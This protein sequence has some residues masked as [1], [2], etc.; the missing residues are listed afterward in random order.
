MTATSATSHRFVLRDLTFPARL[1]V[2]AFMLS[3]GIGYVSAIVNLHMQEASP[4]N[5]LPD[6]DDVV[7]VY[8]GNANASQ[9]ERVLTAHESL[10]F[11]GQGSMRA[12]FTRTRAGNIEPAV[13]AMAKRENCNLDDPAVRAH[14]EGAVLAE[15]DGERQALLAWVRA[16]YP[17]SAYDGDHG[18]ILPDS[19]K[20]LP[21]T[22]SCV[23][24]IDQD[25][26]PERCIKIQ[27]ILR[28]RCV[29]CH[30][31]DVG[32]SAAEYPLQTYEQVAVYCQQPGPGPSGKSLTKLA[33]TT[34][35]HLLGFSMLYGLTGL[36]LAF[37]RL[38]AI[39]RLIL[40]PLPLIAQ[41]LDISCWW[42]AR[43]EGHLGETFA[44]TIPITGGVV[45][46]G[47]VAQI[48]ISV[49]DMYDWKGRFVLLLLFLGAGAGSGF[50][51]HRVV[52]PWLE[53]EKAAA[54]AQ[55][56]DTKSEQKKPD[57]KKSV[58]EPSRLEKLLTP[59]PRQKEVK[60]NGDGQMSAA[61]INEKWDKA[62]AAFQKKNPDVT[63]E[64]AEEALYKEREG[65]WLATLEWVRAGGPQEA[66]EKDAFV[67]SAGLA[68]HPLTP[69]FRADGGKG[70]KIKSILTTR[71][72]R[73]HSAEGMGSAVD[74]PLDSYDNLKA[75]LPRK[76][77]GNGVPNKPPVDQV[78]EPVKQPGG[79]PTDAAPPPEMPRIPRRRYRRAGCI[80][81]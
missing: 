37:S 76:V 45:A 39:L 12:A 63:P 61:F 7:N 52:Q 79:E 36:V 46:L 29:R 74:F 10:P 60:F 17:R 48:L 34:H 38:P 16:G 55:P 53:R 43:L 51:L 44:S 15:M 6:K 22:E 2:T 23:N 56:V 9:M 57:D 65:E 11:N 31:A 62:V 78:K 30:N 13:K 42:L 41:V 28:N 50:V 68:D 80:R 73:C 1:V 35:V 18:F 72:V 81:R 32:G 3:V 77:A 21:V 8:H 4:G 20:N 58:V 75:Y 24:R 26:K 5:P 25:G 19:L 27:T 33:L 70:A 64:A 54:T 67:L 69:G 47:L 40:C 14:C 66:Y 59:E 71:C 49:F